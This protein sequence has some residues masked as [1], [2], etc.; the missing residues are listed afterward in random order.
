MN[1]FKKIGF[2]CLIGFIGL[3][4]IFYFVKNSSK[5]GPQSWNGGTR[6][7]NEGDLQLY[8]NSD[9]GFS[10]NYPKDFKITELSDDTGETILV[11]SQKPEEEF[12]IFISPFDEPEPITADR[13]KKD[14]PDMKIEEP[15]QVLIGADKKINALIFLSENESIGKTR[16]IWFSANGYL[17]QITAKAGQDGFIGPIVETFKI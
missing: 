17:F 1:K 9:I 5:N 7:Q 12:Q 3:I 11:K 8:E 4:G 2:I 16:E 10:F 6:E 15:Q 14:V 13:I